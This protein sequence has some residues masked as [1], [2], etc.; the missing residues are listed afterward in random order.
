ML[1]APCRRRGGMSFWREGVGRSEPCPD[2]RE[3]SPRSLWGGLGRRL[4]CPSGP[5]RQTPSALASGSARQ[6][7]LD[8]SPVGPQCGCGCLSRAAP[9]S[10]RTRQ[11]CHLLQNGLRVTLPCPMRMCGSPRSGRRRQTI[12]ARVRARK[13]GGSSWFVQEGGGS[14]ASSFLSVKTARGWELLTAWWRPMTWPAHPQFLHG[15]FVVCS[16]RRGQQIRASRTGPTL[17][18]EAV[19]R[20]R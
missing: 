18:M 19:M 10:C 12:P 1:R 6:A 20:R 14:L 3:L 11:G 5:Q 13:R 16:G 9:A 4:L 2:N 7:C 17:G 15:T 8:M